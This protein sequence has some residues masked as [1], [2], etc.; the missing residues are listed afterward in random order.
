MNKQLQRE[1]VKLGFNK[2]EVRKDHYDG[3]NSIF[4]IGILVK[5]TYNIEQILD[6]L[7]KISIVPTRVFVEK[8]RC[9]VDWGAQ[10]PVVVTNL[11]DYLNL[12]YE[13]IDYVDTLGLGEWEVSIG[14][15]QDD[16][17]YIGRNK[18]KNSKPRFNEKNFNTIGGFDVI[19]IG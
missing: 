2:G 3:K 11:V 4:K 9:H 15:F 19:P 5:I 13:F 10:R 6:T 7:D 8:N 12:V 14:M 1:M 16:P 18:I 17:H